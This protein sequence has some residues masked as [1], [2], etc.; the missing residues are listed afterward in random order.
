MH[1]LD[2]RVNSVEPA[3]LYNYK[4]LSNEK[5]LACLYTF[6]GARVCTRCTYMGMLLLFRQSAKS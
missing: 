5:K 1:G 3:C 2:V 6:P 4:A